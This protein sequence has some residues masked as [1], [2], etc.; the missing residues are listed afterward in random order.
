MTK[1]IVA[2][3]AAVLALSLGSGLVAGSAQAQDQECRRGA[4]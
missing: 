4:C 3:V 1:R 2:A